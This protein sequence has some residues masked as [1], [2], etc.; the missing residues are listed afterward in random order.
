MRLERPFLWFSQLVD[1]HPKPW[2]HFKID[3]IM[4][5]AYEIMET[6]RTESEVR[7]RGIHDYLGFKGPIT[8]DSGGFLFMQK[9]TLKVDPLSILKLY[10]KSRPDY[11]VVLDHPLGSNL[12]TSERKRRQLRT[13]RNTRHMVESRSSSD[14]E[15]IPVIHGHTSHSIKWYVQELQEIDD[16][17]IYGI[18]SL[19]PSAFNTRGVGGI[20]NVIEILC[21]VRKLLPEKKIHVFGIGSAITMHLMFY[22]GA[23]SVDS[24]SWRSK[25]AFGAIQL[26]G[27]GDR[28]ITSNK[29]HKKYLN[30]SRKEERIL[31]SC[32][33]PACRHHSLGNMR[34]NFQLR[35]LH[36]A[37]VFQNEIKKVR[38]LIRQ[39]R[40]ENY[41][42]KVLKRNRFYP[43]FE[44][45]RKS[46]E[47]SSQI[48]TS[49]A[50]ATSFFDWAQIEQRIYPDFH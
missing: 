10:R 46:M 3:G 44:H 13:L 40:Y 47:R 19:V 12:T 29:K 48:K 37:W 45:V 8:M 20:Y 28:Y 43:V 16:F 39:N 25:A 9:E 34:K 18:G 41:V 32:A 50:Q 1:G 49:T 6:M 24:S 2:E 23:D 4:V 26:A 38:K 5:N 42:E 27:I 21:Q 17:D 31:D 11:G 35:A 36:N 15:L 30:L 22:A 14:P 7:Q 33:C